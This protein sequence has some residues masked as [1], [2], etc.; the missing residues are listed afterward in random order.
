MD[1]QQAKLPEKRLSTVH[2]ALS[3]AA[4]ETKGHV[5]MVTGTFKVDPD[6]LLE[7]Q[8][9]CTR[10]GTN[11]SAYLRSCALCLINDYRD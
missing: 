2:D 6:V 5:K 11:L 3:A 8:K 4:Q 10:N 9:I 7:A 1:S